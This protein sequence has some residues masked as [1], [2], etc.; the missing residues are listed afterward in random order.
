VEWVCPTTTRRCPRPEKQNCGC[1]FPLVS[2][3]EIGRRP[4]STVP[5]H[6]PSR[7]GRR[8]NGTLFRRGVDGPRAGRPKRSTWTVPTEFAYRGASYAR[9]VR[10]ISLPSTRM[11]CRIGPPSA[12]PWL[13]QGM[14][15]VWGT[16]TH[17]ILRG[18][19]RA[20]G[21]HGSG[22]HRGNP[23]QPPTHVRNWRPR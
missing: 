14:Q 21:G 2:M 23:T 13:G 20:P 11:P 7:W 3:S 22:T 1:T 5:A 16:G 10:R 17:Q 19:P 15:R 4:L 6:G 8:F 9:D 18:C 12:I